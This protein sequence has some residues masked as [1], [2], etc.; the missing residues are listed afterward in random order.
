[1]LP[2]VEMEYKMA[3]NIRANSDSSSLKG[4][5]FDAAQK[6][7]TRSPPSQMEAYVMG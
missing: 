6:G 3:T 4:A 5:H 1:M 2:S 7:M